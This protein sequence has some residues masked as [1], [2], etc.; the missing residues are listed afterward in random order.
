[1]KVTRRCGFAWVFCAALLPGQIVQ[2][3]TITTIV[4][5][6]GTPGTPGG[7]VGDGGPPTMANLNLPF[8]VVFSA[9]NLYIA[10]EADNLIRF[11]SKGTITSI[12][13]VG[14]AGD[15]GD[16]GPATQAELDSPSGL[17]VDG[18]GNVYIADTGNGVIRFVAQATGK[19]STTVYPGN[20]LFPGSFLLPSGLAMDS[21]G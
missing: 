19:I 16:K 13:G 4:G 14:T 20:T 18:S 2:Q 17:A 12:A 15:T 3:Y 21:S 6:Q 5:T 9:G 8:A 7:T 10:D 11:V 1:M